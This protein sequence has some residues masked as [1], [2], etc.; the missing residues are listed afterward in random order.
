MYKHSDLQHGDKLVKLPYGRPHCAAACVDVSRLS[1]DK[2]ESGDS[3]RKRKINGRRRRHGKHAA[4]TGH[5]KQAQCTYT[6]IISH[7][8]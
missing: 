5:N 4:D 1:R 3:A 2:T 6:N 8:I 7:D